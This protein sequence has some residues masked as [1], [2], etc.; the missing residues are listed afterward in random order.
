MMLASIVLATVLDAPAVVVTAICDGARRKTFA[1][2]ASTTDPNGNVF[3]FTTCGKTPSNALVTCE[4]K[5]RSTFCRAKLITS[6]YG[7]VV[8]CVR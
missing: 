8:R 4:C 7:D 1:S 5:P 2:I 6:I 3:V